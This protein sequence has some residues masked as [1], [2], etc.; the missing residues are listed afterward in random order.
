[1]K[2]HIYILFFI[3]VFTQITLSG[4]KY[5][6]LSVGP[7][8]GVSWYNGDLNHSRQFYRIHP[9]FG[10]FLRYAVGDR[11]AYTASINSVGVSGKY[12]FEGNYYPNSENVDYQ[13]K[14]NV[15][16][17]A[18]MMEINFF[19]F[20]HPYDAS[21]RFTPYLTFGLGG[22]IYDRYKEQEGKINEKPTFVL[23]LP[24]GAGVKWKINRWTQVG[25]QW[26]FRKLTAD[27]IDYVGFTNGINPQDPFNYRTR[28]VIHNNDWYSIFGVYLSFQIYTKGGKCFDG[29]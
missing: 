25:A 16:D 27:D 11:I 4:Q 20:D 21:A 23:S 9:S 2:L 24:F 6:R 28:S 8:A 12:K 15:I 5:A 19:S 17:V 10:G 1:M 29:F 13:F 3:F 18:T 7:A 14:R 22:A 26:S